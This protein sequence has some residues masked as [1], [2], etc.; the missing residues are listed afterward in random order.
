MG[1]IH[2]SALS[3]GGVSHRRIKRDMPHV[4]PH[5][6][7]CYPGGHRMRAVGVAHP[8]RGFCRKTLGGRA[9]LV[10]TAVALLSLPAVC[11]QK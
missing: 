10:E 2:A 1:C 11:A 8:M 5:Y 4:L 7:Q 9:L 3:A 6:V